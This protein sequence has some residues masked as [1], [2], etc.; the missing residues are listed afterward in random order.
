MSKKLITL[1]VIVVVWIAVAVAAIVYG[2][3]N[4]WN[5]KRLM[6]WN[7]ISFAD[8]QSIN[9]PQEI[10][11]TDIQSRL[12]SAPEQYVGSIRWV[13][14]FLDTTYGYIWYDTYLGSD[15]DGQSNLL[16][17]NG[18]YK[19]VCDDYVLYGV[20]QY[21]KFY[22]FQMF[23]NNEF[24]PLCDSSTLDLSRYTAAPMMIYI[25]SGYGDWS[26]LINGTGGPSSPL[27]T[28]FKT[29]KFYSLAV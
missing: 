9:N 21:G 11:V 22:L 10:A 12:L 1:T 28:T 20:A 25:T 17:A 13:D 2:A 3:L 14:E 6:F 26:I 27:I 5:Y 4:D 19:V 8:S 18:C 24:I 7:N 23:E 29:V 16:N 15:T